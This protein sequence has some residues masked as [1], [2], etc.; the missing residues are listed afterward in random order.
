MFR[1][2]NLPQSCHNKDTI[3]TVA[4]SSDS[5]MIA[6]GS[7]DGSIQV[8]DA[9]TG[10][11]IYE[12]EGHTDSVW[13]VDFSPD[14]RI[15]ISA[16]L[17]GTIQLWDLVAPGGRLVEP[18]QHNTPFYAV[19]FSQDGRNFVTSGAERE[20]R[21]W[22]T[23]TRELTSTLEGHND[24][25][26]TVELSPDGTTLASGSLDGT[27]R[28]WDMR[29]FRE[30]LVLT[31]HTGG[32]K[33]LTY[34][35]DNRILT[36]GAG[37]DNVQ[38]A[39]PTSNFKNIYI[40]DI[41][42]YIN[43]LTALSALALTDKVGV[44]DVSENVAGSA[45]AQDVLNTVNTTPKVSVVSAD[46]KIPIT[47]ASGVVQHATP[48]QIGDYLATG[49]I[50][51]TA[52]ENIVVAEN[53]FEVVCWDV[54]QG[55]S[56]DVSS[57]QNYG[58]GSMRSVTVV[59]GRLYCLRNGSSQLLHYDLEVSGDLGI[60]HELRNVANTIYASV[61]RIAVFENTLFVAK[62][63]QGWGARKLDNLQASSFN[64]TGLNTS[65][66]IYDV[67]AYDDKLY[68]LGSTQIYVYD[69]ASTTSESHGQSSARYLSV[70]KH[71]IYVGKWGTP[72]SVRFKT[73][74]AWTNITYQ[75]LN[76]SS[77]NSV[78][79]I[80]FSDNLVFYATDNDLYWKSLDSSGLPTG[81][82]QSLENITSSDVKQIVVSDRKVYLI[83]TATELVVIDMPISSA[84]IVKY[85][86]SSFE[87]P[88]GVIISSATANQLI[89]VFRLKTLSSVPS[90]KGLVA[91]ESYTESGWRIGLAMTNTSIIIDL[92]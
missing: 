20:V 26:P 44:Y 15:L 79:T 77:S 81:S 69:G 63:T 33:A 39:D 52:K 86:D 74:G 17:D 43:L 71:G 59:G 24:I 13:E 38:P 41:F 6:G 57:L 58:I 87:K 28:L 7:E 51:A 78:E 92:I 42:K 48:D 82:V 50:K 4:F 35:E 18:T 84:K 23:H 55:N 65:G 30:R 67:V 29:L 31:G 76:L 89:N 70:N 5:Q 49:S 22:S 11:R 16:S 37:L 72:S 1:L 27:V 12:F 46:S 56:I 54:E 3:N 36:C 9:G 85:S 88:L 21:V 68:L 62:G 47:N 19:D 34:S 60:E 64:P 90:S 40:P 45:T 75:Q 14:G 8:W 66:N 73:G 32:I 91:G 80:T 25:V 10:D 83:S 2:K 53:D 61:L